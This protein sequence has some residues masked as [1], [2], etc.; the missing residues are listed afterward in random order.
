MVTTQHLC[1]V[2]RTPYDDIPTAADHEKIPVTHD[3]LK[4]GYVFKFLGYYGAVI[5]KALPSQQHVQNYEILLIFHGDFGL[6]YNPHWAHRN[7]MQGDVKQIEQITDDEFSKIRDGMAH[8][9]ESDLTFEGSRKTFKPED[10]PA[11]TNKLKQE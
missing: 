7:L 8:W 2:C 9:F 4:P 11:L 6:P 10:I 5:R 1:D 3:N